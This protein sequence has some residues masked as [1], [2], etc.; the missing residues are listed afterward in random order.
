MRRTVMLTLTIIAVAFLIPTAVMLGI[1]HQ[2]TKDMI[3]VEGTI[4]NWDGDH[5]II[6]YTV[7]GQEYVCRMSVSSSMHWPVG[8]PYRL[9]A[10]PE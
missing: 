6:A 10:D 3:P 5:P 1:F 2:Q 7:N 8:S 9:M 4:A